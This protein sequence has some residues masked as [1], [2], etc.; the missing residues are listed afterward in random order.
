MN[1]FLKTLLLSFF[2]FAYT[3][4]YAK[5]SIHQTITIIGTAD[6][7]G[8]MQARTQKVDLNF[9]GKKQKMKLGGIDRLATLITQI[10]KENPYTVAVSTGDDL[11]NRFFHTFK[12][13]AILSL[14]SDA[15]YDL[16]AFGNHE[17]DKGS[18]VL[19][20]ALDDTKFQAICSDLD[21][22]KSALNGKCLPY[23]IKDFN[24]VKVGFFSLMTEDLPLVTS[25]RNVTMISDNVTTAKKMV[26]FLDNNGTDI[27]IALSHIGYKE[28]RK[29]AKQVKGIDLIFGGHSHDY[30]KEMGHINNTAI[31]NGGEKGSQLV[32]V[33]IP[34]DS[35]KKVLH[36]QIVMTKIA[37]KQSIVPNEAISKKVANYVKQ[38]P[39]A[40]VLG[41]TK[42]EW[43]L[44]ADQIRKGESTVA[45]M[46]N[47]LMREQFKVDIVL[48]N[49]GAFRGQKTYAPGPITDNMLKEID[50]FGNYAYTFK[51][52]GKYI[53]E[54]LEWSASNYGKGGFLQPSGLRYRITLSKEIMLAEK[55]KIMQEGSRV[56]NIEVLVGDTWK[57][58][59]DEREYTVL[60]N[61]FLVQHAGDG[62][63]WFNEYGT[64]LK[65]TYATFYSLMADF[66]HKYKTLSPKEKDGRVVVVQ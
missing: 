9:D 66:L 51:L 23:V 12:G 60:S 14:L 25:E 63:F 65:N 62:Y 5:E 16:Y 52:K 38:F 29:L 3:T 4:G 20:K 10:K 40:I 54:V 64:N 41:D 42:N 55:N 11:M 43:N 46:I 33:D 24:G 44:H 8:M 21:V 57:A 47:D 36:K 1:T 27:I 6:L 35:N 37:V 30:I 53:K 50:E 2:L 34:L 32:V 28:D 22:S 56:D 31:V 58:L 61:S 15:G 7:Q 48:N 49:G 39:E 59:D 18:A 45:S 17:F 19:A 26:E 13:S